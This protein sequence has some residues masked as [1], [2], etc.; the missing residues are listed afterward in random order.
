VG[1]W[2]RAEFR[3]GR[4]GSFAVA[5]VSTEGAGRHLALDADGTATPLASFKGSPD[6]ACYSR[7]E[8]EKLDAS[9]KVSETIQGSVTPRWNSTVICGFVEDTEAVCWQYSPDE[10]VFVIIGGWVT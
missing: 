1:A 10:R 6:L 9:I 3:A 5:I 4:A 7:R 8:A 2:C